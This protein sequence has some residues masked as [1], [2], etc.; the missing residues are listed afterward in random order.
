MQHISYTS[1][2]LMYY[3]GIH[4]VGDTSIY[5]YMCCRGNL[6]KYQGI[7]DTFTFYYYTYKSMVCS[8]YILTNNF[9]YLR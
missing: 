9:N 2:S 5:C 6:R 8:I 7:P 1:L 4:S 3:T